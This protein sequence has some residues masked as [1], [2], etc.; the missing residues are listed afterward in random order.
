MQIEGCQYLLEYTGRPIRGSRT[1][2]HRLR[3]M[4]G[5]GK[6]LVT[7][8]IFQAVTVIHYG[9]FISCTVEKRG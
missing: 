3:P 6:Q 8:R 4:E 5:I 7:N 1:L 9:D 2:H